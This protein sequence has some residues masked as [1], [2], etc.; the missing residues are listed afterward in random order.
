VFLEIVQQPVAQI[1]CS[2]S[3]TRDLADRSKKRLR[4][5][6]NAE[7]LTYYL[8]E[9]CV[10][11]VQNL[12]KVQMA[13]MEQGQA[14]SWSCGFPSRLKSVCKPDTFRWPSLQLFR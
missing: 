5:Y 13:G 6:T 1:P 12:L 4:L 8:V 2:P 7:A 9:Q 11:A 10:S 3:P 14:L